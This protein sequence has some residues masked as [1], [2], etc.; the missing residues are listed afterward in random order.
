M[1]ALKLS[2]ITN[3]VLLLLTEYKKEYLDV[4]KKSL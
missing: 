1:Y 3:M 2:S 4:A